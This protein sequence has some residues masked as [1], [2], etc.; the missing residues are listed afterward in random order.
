MARYRIP[1][2]VAV[3]LLL[4][5]AGVSL[6]LAAGP[7][8]QGSSDEECLVCHGNPSLTYEFPSGET[9]SLY[10]NPQAH[11]DSVHGQQGVSC[12]TCHPGFDTY[13]HA[14][15]TV[16]SVRAYQ[17]DQYRSC[18]QCH[19]EVYEESLDSIHADEIAG[20]DWSAPVCTDCHSAHE[21]T[22]P[23]EPRTRIPLACSRCHSAIY[24]EYHGSVHGEA[25]TTGNPDVPTCTDCHGVHTQEDPRT[26]QFRLNSPALCATCHADAE[27]MGR[28]G[29]STDVFDTYVADFHGTTV[30]LFERQSPDQETNKPVC[31]DCH[32]V[33]N[34]QPADDPGSSVFRA[35]LLRTCQR[36]HPDATDEF[37]VSWLSHYRPDLERYPLVYLVETFYRILIPSVLGFMA[38]FVAVDGVSHLVRRVRAKKSKESA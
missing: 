13:P 4:A 18:I 38:I 8:P 11:Q 22:S 29:L 10:V 21:T 34:M 19:D 32:G 2:A 23:H 12:A 24:D 1:I 35:N 7:S 14:P 17:L 27:M 33:H 9:W 20:G 25:L 15:L 6:A 37:P 30:T 3:G 26:T 28:Y 31:Y 5:L 36:C 16:A